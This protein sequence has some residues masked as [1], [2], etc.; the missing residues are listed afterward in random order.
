MRLVT[1]PPFRGENAFLPALWILSFGPGSRESCG[2]NEKMAKGQGIPWPAWQAIWNTR[3]V[4]GWCRPLS[5][6]AIWSALPDCVRTFVCCGSPPAGLE[7]AGHAACG[8][9]RGMQSEVVD[10]ILLT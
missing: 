2:G 10:R 4:G 7:G 9:L 5:L 3:S 1:R 6:T 8:R